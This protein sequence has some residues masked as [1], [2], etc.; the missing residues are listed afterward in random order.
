MQAA[1]RG[2]PLLL[3]AAAAAGKAMDLL[4]FVFMQLQKKVGIVTAVVEV[5]G[6]RGCQGVKRSE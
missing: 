5:R 1:D 4:D 6:P 2:W 3:A